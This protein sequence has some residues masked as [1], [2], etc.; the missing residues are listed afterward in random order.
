MNT[1]PI[2]GIIILV[3]SV[4]AQL[5][6]VRVDTGVVV[7]AVRVVEVVDP[8]LFLDILALLQSPQ[9]HQ[10]LLELALVVRLARLAPQI[11]FALFIIQD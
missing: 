10:L 2:V 7:A 3:A 11:I 4:L 5:R 8:R 1:L 6:A 9:L